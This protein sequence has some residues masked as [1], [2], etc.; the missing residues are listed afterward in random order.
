MYFSTHIDPR[1]TAVLRS[2]C[3]LSVDAASVFSSRTNRKTTTTSRG[4]PDSGMT[5]LK[6]C[7]DAANI[8]AS[9][10][11]PLRFASAGRRGFISRCGA[12]APHRT[13]AA[14]SSTASTSADNGGRR[15][16]TRSAMR[17]PPSSVT[18]RKT[19]GI[20]NTSAARVMSSRGASR[21]LEVGRAATLLLPVAAD[22]GQGV[23]LGA[24]LDA[25]FELGF[26]L[27]AA[28]HL[29]VRIVDDDAA[30]RRGGDRA[31]DGCESTRVQIFVDGHAT[32]SLAVVAV[33]DVE[34]G[35]R[36]LVRPV[37]A[38]EGEPGGGKLIGAKEAEA[39]GERLLVDAIDAD[40][41]G[42]R[43]ARFGKRL[44]LARVDPGDRAEAA[45]RERQP[46][47]PDHA[48]VH[49]CA[50]TGRKRPKCSRCTCLPAA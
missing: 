27:V 26:Q 36:I 4:S 13:S 14:S 22:D 43:A 7:T 17:T 2:T 10:V 48:V 6:A 19:S 32:P 28:A 21:R 38:V 42:E 47:R 1:V 9:T 11:T 40:R 35:A 29:E 18:V 20:Q 46:A 44:R 49:A 31:I 34:L 12:N 5:L 41:G 25:C 50:A 33:G 45:D 8:V 37:G 30:P 15:K 16:T 24:G 3:V 23:D 39:V